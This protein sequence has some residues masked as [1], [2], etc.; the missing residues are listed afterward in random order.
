MNRFPYLVLYVLEGKT[1]A[2]I[3]VFHTGRNPKIWKKRVK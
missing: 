1:I 3:S 2:V